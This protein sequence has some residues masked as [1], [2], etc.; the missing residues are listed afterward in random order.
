M[1]RYFIFGGFLQSSREGIHF[2]I[3]VSARHMY[4]RAD[5]FLCSALRNYKYVFV[6]YEFDL[7]L[8]W[9]N[10]TIYF[11]KQVRPSLSLPIL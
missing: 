9:I 5:S 10:F 3:N 8:Y 4:V 7:I 11:I 6:Y 2:T 1:E